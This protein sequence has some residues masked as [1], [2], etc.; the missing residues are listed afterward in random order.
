[1]S[2][3][4]AVANQKGGV[5]KSTT[6]MNLAAALVQLGLRGLV[7]D[8]DP[9]GNTSM[10]CGIEKNALKISVYHAL[11]GV[12][13]FSD[14]VQHAA[15][16][17]FDILPA[18]RELAGAE[19]ELISL[20]RREFRLKELL[21]EERNYD[22]VLLDCPP[23]LNLLT[24]NGLVAADYVLIPMQCE[25]YALEGL[26]DLVTTLKQVTATLNPKLEIL[27]VLRTMVDNRNMLTQQVSQELL[28]HFRTQLFQTMIP[29]NV[30]IA[31]APSH[32]MP[33]L[34]YDKKARGAQAYCEL[35]QEVLT[36]LP[37]LRAAIGEKK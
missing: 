5:G 29:R 32:G 24:L 1:M 30:R 2:V 34:A 13:W 28:T 12:A 22:F 19:L 25:Y 23:S 27:G 15:S 36:R 4:I 18:N 10:G 37:Q 11:I 35:A 7:V 26:T 31:E 3:V 8:L 21:C 33:V 6:V 14:V 9:Q 17:G 16:G 20:E